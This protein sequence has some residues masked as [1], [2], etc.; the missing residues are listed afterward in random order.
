MLLWNG[1]RLDA[2]RQLAIDKVLDES[3]DFLLGELVTLEW[4]LLVLDSLLDGERREGVGRKIEVTG[5]STE[6]L[7]IDGCDVDFAS[8]FLSHRFEGLG[9]LG[10]LLFGLSE[11]VAQRK[12]SLRLLVICTLDRGSPTYSHVASV[13]LRTDLTNQWC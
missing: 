9:E 3:S 4:V 5:M 8:E 13:R 2:R 6:G 1:L 12:T 10:A 11:D 7:G